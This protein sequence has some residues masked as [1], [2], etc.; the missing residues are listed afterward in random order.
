MS[1]MR[2]T[3]PWHVV[4]PTPLFT[5]MLWLKYTKSG[6][7][8]TRT[9][10]IDLP[11]R[12]LSRTGSRNGLVEKICEWQF[13]HVLVGGI[14]ANDESSTDVWQYRQSMPLPAT[15]RSW[16]NWIGCSLATWAVVTH[17]ERLI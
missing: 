8:W 15:C 10:A 12:K 4:H 11:D 5:W 6:R 14:P 13:M 17:D 3:G 1:G 7:S 9:H 2:S 16:L